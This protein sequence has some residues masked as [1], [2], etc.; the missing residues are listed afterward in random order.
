MIRKS[1]DLKMQATDVIA[2]LVK[3]QYK[4]FFLENIYLHNALEISNNF[5]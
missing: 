2:A 5:Y 3:K 4:K 1:K